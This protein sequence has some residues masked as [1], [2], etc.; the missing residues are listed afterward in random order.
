MLKPGRY[1]EGKRAA[2]VADVSEVKKARL[3]DDE[4]V[5]MASVTELP[6]NKRMHYSIQFGQRR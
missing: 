1:R 4:D 2:E 6:T 3:D 5:L